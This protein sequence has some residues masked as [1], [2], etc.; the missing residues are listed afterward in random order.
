[1]GIPDRGVEAKRGWVLTAERKFNV[2][3]IYRVELAPAPLVVTVRQFSVGSIF[4]SPRRRRNAVY[5]GSTDGNLY[6]VE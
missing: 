4:S 2:P 3:M 1:M 5:F 6:A